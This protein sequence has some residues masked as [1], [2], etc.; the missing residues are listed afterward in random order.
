MTAVRKELRRRRGRLGLTA[1]LHDARG[2]CSSSPSRRSST[3]GTSP[4]EAVDGNIIVDAGRPSTGGASAR[5]GKADAPTGSADDSFGQGTKEDT[6]VRSVIDGSI[7]NNK[8]DLK[9]FGVYSK[10][11]RGAASWSCSGHRVQEP[12]GT[13]NMDFEFNQ[14]ST[15]S[16]NGVTPVRTAGDVLIE[17][18]LSQGGTNL[19]CSPSRWV[20]VGRGLAVRGEQRRCRAGTTRI[21]LT[22]AGIATGSINTL[23]I[24]AANSDG[25]GAFS[26]SDV[27]RGRGRPVRPDGGGAGALRRHSVARTSRAARRTRSR[28]R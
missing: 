5:P 3:I 13:T 27:R 12:Q 21:N 25:L 14:S 4:F 28:R 11:S 2:A 17:Y 16:A 8:S 15:I 22:A 1:M 23:P 20:T 10:P 6:P 24:T 19:S 26:A 9:Q 18:D 7:P